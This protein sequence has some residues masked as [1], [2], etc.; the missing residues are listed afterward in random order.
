MLVQLSF[1]LQGTDDIYESADGYFIE[2]RFG[3]CVS[4]LVVQ[5]SDDLK[6]CAGPHHF[7]FIYNGTERSGCLY[8]NESYFSETFPS[9]I[10][11]SSQELY[12]SLYTQDDSCNIVTTTTGGS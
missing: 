10:H 11:D 9:M 1:L 8:S 6:L 7:S 2:N 5:Y 4:K 3:G 12:S